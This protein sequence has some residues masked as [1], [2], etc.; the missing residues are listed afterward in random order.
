MLTWV[1]AV[2]SQ[3]PFC[4]FLGNRSPPDR[5]YSRPMQNGFCCIACDGNDA[6][7]EALLAIVLPQGSAEPFPA[8]RAGMPG[9]PM[10]ARQ[11]GDRL[12]RTRRHYGNLF[13]ASLMHGM[14]TAISR[15]TAFDNRASLVINSGARVG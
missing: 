14:V 10:R 15:G 11:R 12:A 6:T 1:N 9:N 7:P 4:E 2:A 13:Y 3:I 5:H 8:H